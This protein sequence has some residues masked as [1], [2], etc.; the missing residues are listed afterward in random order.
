MQS[1]MTPFKHAKVI[2]TPTEREHHT[3]HGLHINKK[4]KYWIA[5]NLVKEI[6]NSYLPL[7]NNPPIVLQW[8]N[9]NI[10]TTQ[11]NNSEM[12][13]KMCRDMEPPHPGEDAD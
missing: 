12:P 2:N 13:N 11:Q 9:N 6:K 1:L 10:N 7:N 4:G 5:N 8:K 3:R